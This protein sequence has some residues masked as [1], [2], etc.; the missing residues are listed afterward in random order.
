MKKTLREIAD[1]VGGRVVGDENIVISGLEN[2][3][4][5][6]EHD[7]TFAVEPHLDDDGSFWFE[8]D[9]EGYNAAAELYRRVNKNIKEGS[10][11]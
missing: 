7:L 3:E 9:D 11:S 4:G 10:K 8:F 6:G 1:Y 5:A 2:I